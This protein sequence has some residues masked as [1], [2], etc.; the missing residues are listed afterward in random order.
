MPRETIDKSSFEKI[1]FFC[2]VL[3]Y[4]AGYLST[5]RSEF[6]K[7]ERLFP[8]N[9][10]SRTA[11]NGYRSGFVFEFE[12]GTSLIERLI[13]F[14]TDRRHESGRTEDD[15]HQDAGDDNHIGIGGIHEA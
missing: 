7:S 12:L 3:F 5:T 15:S 14:G 9:E 8:C 1:F 11:S 10:K 13:L 6:L 4:H 2:I